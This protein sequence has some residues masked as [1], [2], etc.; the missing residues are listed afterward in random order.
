MRLLKSIYGLR[1]APSIFSSRLHEYLLKMGFRANEI[2]RRLYIKRHEDGSL[3]LLGM[4]VDDGIVVETKKGNAQWA[5]EQLSGKYNLTT[6][7]N[8]S[9]Y[10][11]LEI[12]RDRENKVLKLHQSTYVRKIL[13]EVNMQPHSLKLQSPGVAV[14]HLSPTKQDIAQNR[15]KLGMLIYLQRTRPALACDIN[16]S[17]KTLHYEMS[18]CQIQMDKILQYVHQTPSEGLTFYG[19]NETLHIYCAA[20]AS[21]QSEFIG[22]KEPH[23]GREL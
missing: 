18:N 8:P 9:T 2:D 3:T 16:K 23:Q 1:A 20:D 15:K 14:D 21:F 10:L 7:L 13:K 6:E 4:H 5:I 17:A 11:G 22:T 19:T 12:L